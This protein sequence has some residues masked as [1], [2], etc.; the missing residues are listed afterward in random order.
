MISC[1]LITS[2]DELTAPAAKVTFWQTRCRSNGSQ[3]TYSTWIHSNVTYNPW[4][5][6]GVMAGFALELD[7]ERWM[8]LS[9]SWARSD[10]LGDQKSGDLTVTKEGDGWQG[11]IGIHLR[12][13]LCT[14]VTSSPPLCSQAENWPFWHELP[15]PFGSAHWSQLSTI[16]SIHLQLSI[17]CSLLLQIW[18]L[19]LVSCCCCCSLP[20]WSPWSVSTEEDYG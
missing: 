4:T 14:E 3:V 9:L 16:D 15:R 12:P 8:C 5:M 2:Q 11:W 10:L 19:V 1:L 13:V 20:L 6:V 18:L 17:I 7:L